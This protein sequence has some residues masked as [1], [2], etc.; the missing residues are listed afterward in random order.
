[1]ARL[2]IRS[3]ERRQVFAILDDEFTLGAGPDNVLRLDRPGVAETHL[4]F[5][6]IGGDRVR[7]E[8]VDEGAELRIGGRV[9]RAHLLAHG[10]RIDVADVALAFWEDGRDEPEVVLPEARP[11][12]VDDPK[13]GLG[14]E[15]RALPGVTRAPVPIGPP[16]AMPKPAG[17]PGPRAPSRTGSQ[18][19]R[20]P[21]PAPRTSGPSARMIRWNAA[22]AAVALGL[23]LYRCVGGPGDVKPV[24]DLIRLAETQRASGAVDDARRTLELALDRGPTPEEAERAQRMLRTIDTAARVRSG[25]D[26]RD[27]AFRDLDQLRRF[28]SRYLGDDTPPRPAAREGLALCAAW[29]DEHRAAADTEV[30]R[31]WLDEVE[32]LAARCRRSAAAGEPDSAEDVLF[33]AG[34]RARFRP[35]HFPEAIRILSGWLDGAASDAPGRADV[36]AERQRFLEQGREEFESEM[37]RLEPVFAGGDVE[38]AI[39]E[40]EALIERAGLPDWDGDARSR[41]AGL[42]AQRGS[43][44]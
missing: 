33:A 31:E 40:L 27:R 42:R 18:D 29:I 43:G 15:I 7:V 34:R 4:R 28:A 19:E 44:G 24:A 36:E 32:G 5:V 41:L 10:D 21:A 17:A 39:V 23:V 22:V 25:Q 8:P 2:L 9:R 35:R 37:R 26:A 13:A 30:A 38:R 16:R 1:M 11:T 20:D 12:D 14:I 6:A 3:G